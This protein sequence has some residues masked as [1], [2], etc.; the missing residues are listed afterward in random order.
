MY[1]CDPPKI[2]HTIFSSFPWAGQTTFCEL[3]A[4]LICR[5]SN[6]AALEI[7]VQLDVGS[8]PAVRNANDQTA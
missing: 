8:K 2:V 6:L 3:F 1:P 4:H 7:A 5:L